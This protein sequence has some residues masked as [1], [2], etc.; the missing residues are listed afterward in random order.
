MKI[1]YLLQLTALSALWG[2]SFMLTQIAAPQFGPNLAAALRMGMATLVLWLIMRKYKQ[3]WPLQHWRELLLLGF[4]AVAGPHV[5]LAFSALTLPAGYGS[6]LSVTSVM[7]SAVASALLKE[8][9]LTV[10][11]MLSCLLGLVGA[12]LI[13]KLGP[14]EPSPALVSGALIC[15][16]SAAL[17]GVSTPY[18][19]K[20]ILR[21]EPLAV[22]AGMHAAAL[23][24]MLPGALYDLPKAHFSLP[25]FAAVSLMGVFTSG[26]AYWIYLRI[27]QYIPPMAAQSATFLST[28][29]GVLWAILLLGEA[30]GLVLWVGAGLIVLACLLIFEINPMRWKLGYPS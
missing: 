19:K 15:I 9:I 2:A 8:E 23:L 26:L 12:G 29:F 16:A 18:L 14:V 20:A 30:T 6:L 1:K 7:F 25:A 22:T 11:K 5:L 27:M 4:L 21:M 24:L 28:G 13:V 17:S 10:R 3:T